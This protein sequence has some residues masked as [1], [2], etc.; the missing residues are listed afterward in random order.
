MKIV[1][2]CVF[3]N[4]YPDEYFINLPP[5]TKECCQEI[6]DIVN[7]TQDVNCTRY[8][9]VVPDNYKLQPGFEP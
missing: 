3:G 6:A 2:T 9:K 1:N 4:D 8:W 5:L 7:S